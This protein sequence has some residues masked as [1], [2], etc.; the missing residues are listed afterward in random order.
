MTSTKLT[1]LTSLC[2]SLLLATG[3]I[4]GHNEPITGILGAL[5]VELE[6]LNDQVLRK[7][8]LTLS[9]IDFTVGHL[10]GRK[11]V[12]ARTGVGKVNATETATLL[13]EHFSPH[14][15]IFTGV[16]GGLNP[17]LLPTD[18]IIGKKTVQHDL[19]ILE[20]DSYEPYAVRNPL[21][22]K[23]NPIFFPAD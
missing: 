2:I 19:I 1:I 5:D 15:V 4:S 11:V 23:R 12:F 9:G 22:G 20:V 16:A 21:S 3:C 17:N 18:I 14:E 8:K 13:I 10:K 7:Q 6:A